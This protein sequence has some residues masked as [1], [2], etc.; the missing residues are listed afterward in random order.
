MIEQF[1]SNGF[2]WTQRRDFMHRALGAIAAPPP[3]IRALYPAN[4]ERQYYALIEYQNRQ[5]KAPNVVFTIVNGGCGRGTRPVC[6]GE[7]APSLPA[8]PAAPP[9]PPLPPAGLVSSADQDD[10]T[11]RKPSSSLPGSDISTVAGDGPKRRAR[12]A[13]GLERVPDRTAANEAVSPTAAADQ[14]SSPEEAEDLGVRDT[15]GL[16]TA[17]PELSESV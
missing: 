9:L 4:Q 17:K 8:A 5:G 16:E 12:S 2:G 1:E 14:A 10:S 11:V 6:H 3:N 15:S 13:I 7:G